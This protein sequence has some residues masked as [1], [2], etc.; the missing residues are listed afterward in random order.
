MET[1]KKVQEKKV[2]RLYNIEYI[3]VHYYQRERERVT[4]RSNIKFLIFYTH[5]I[6]SFKLFYTQVNL[7]KRILVLKN[8]V[9]IFKL[10]HNEEIALS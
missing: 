5:T 8:I 2:C 10:Y 9:K 1:K 7:F 6:F 3:K 4:K